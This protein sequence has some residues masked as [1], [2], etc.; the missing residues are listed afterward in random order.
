MFYYF[1][2]VTLNLYSM[3]RLIK[4]TLPIILCAICSVCFAQRSLKF[5]P[6]TLD[7]DSVYTDIKYVKNV[8]VTNNTTSTLS[9]TKVICT[10]H[11]IKTEY[12][13]SPIG[14]GESVNIKITCSFPDYNLPGRY[15]YIIHF[16]T[17][18]GELS[19]LYVKYFKVD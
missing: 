5:N 12:P 14:S 7:L 16:R 3:I 10:S 13:T 4:K 9:I 19:K 18:D 1:C 8:I 17:S 15:D 2:N 11:F 6:S